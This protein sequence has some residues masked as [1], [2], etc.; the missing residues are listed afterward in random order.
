MIKSFACKDTEKLF[1]DQW[2]KRFQSIE[3][4]ARKKLMS[5]HAAPSL[6]SLMLIPGNKLHSL[7]G[8]R[9]GQYAISINDQWRI[10]FEWND[11]HANNVQIIDYH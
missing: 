2:V 4:Q 3:R 8:N 11:G 7:S 10:C 1:T 9:Q 5:L 6:Q